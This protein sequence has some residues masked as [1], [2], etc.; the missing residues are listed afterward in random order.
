MAL[1]LLTGDVNLMKV[2]DAAVPFGRVA[3]ELHKADVIFSNLECLL[4]A[5][6]GY[7]V[8]NEGFFADPAIGGDRADYVTPRATVAL[9]RYMAT[10]P[11]FQ[12]YFEALPVLG[13]DGTLASSVKADSP[14][15]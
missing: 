15:R 12:V 10:R 6:P 8:S 14:A 13:V 7:S 5:A 11:D 1:L 3:D 4:Y 9:L 2:T